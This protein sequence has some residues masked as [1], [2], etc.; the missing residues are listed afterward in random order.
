MSRRKMWGF[1]EVAR[2]FGMS[3]R[4]V[5]RMAAAGVLP[6]AP[7]ADW[8]EGPV[9]K[10]GTRLKKDEN[11][12]Q[13][14]D[15]F[16]FPMREAFTVSKAVPKMFF[17]SDIK[18]LKPYELRVNWATHVVTV[19]MALADERGEAFDPKWIEAGLKAIEERDLTALNFWIE[20]TPEA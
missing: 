11:G 10:S 5:Q 2:H 15:D 4:L 9:T 13:V 12:V 18:K 20:H 6:V 19:R 8:K 7:R 14:Y 1:R 16:G 17:I 3:W